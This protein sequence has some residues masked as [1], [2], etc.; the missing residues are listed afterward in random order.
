MTDLTH[1]ANLVEAFATLAE[2]LVADYDAV[3]VLQLLVD[4]CVTFLDAS[5]AGVLIGDSADE[6]ELVA[7]TS[8]A[9]SIVELMQLAAHEGP[10]IDSFSTG[11][12]ISV[13]KIDDSP[14]RW[15]LFQ[16]SAREQ[17]FRSALSVPMRVRGT[18][19]GALNLLR[20]EEGVLN[21]GD[22]R[23]AQALADVA[24]IGIIHERMLSESESIRAQLQSALNSRIIIEQAKGVLAFLHNSSTDEAF[25][26]LRGYAR[27][28]QMLLSVVAEQVV[29][30]TLVI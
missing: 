21:D 7:S 11:D 5:S 4:N 18:R 6:L 14:E 9:S 23:A 2:S 8:E 17:G 19:V 24:T 27:K 12:I 3:G 13:A 26:K 20:F 15:T 1:Q 10:C 25:A 30:R 29:Q 28:N 22:V 16:N